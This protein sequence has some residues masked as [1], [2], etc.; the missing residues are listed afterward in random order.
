MVNEDALWR[1]N[2][3]AR[4]P[5]S[6]LNPPEFFKGY[7][8]SGASLRMITDAEVAAEALSAAEKMF[9]AEN[10]RRASIDT[11]S[12]TVLGATGLLGAIVVAAGQFGLASSRPSLS[13][14]GDFAVGFYFATL[15][16]LGYT[17][18]LSITAHTYPRGDVVSPDDLV[19]GAQD[20]GAVPHAQYR[21]TACR[22]PIKIYE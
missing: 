5:E 11:R 15:L 20:A 21:A 16:Y 22:P 9:D 12:G 14:A 18:L 3:P 10:G 1:Q 8:A 2:F 19:V 7:D 17:V 6:T 13:I 4:V